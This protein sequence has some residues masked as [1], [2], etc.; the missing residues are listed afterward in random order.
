VPPQFAPSGTPAGKILQARLDA[1]VAQHPDLRIQVRIKPVDG[2]GGLLDSLTTSSAAAPLALPDLVALP[3]PL[4]ETAALKG[5]L[6]PF[7]GLI[8]DPEDSDWFDYALRL[9]HL[10]DSLF[11]LPFSG[12]ALVLVYRSEIISQP[13]ATMAQVLQ[14]S[15]ALAFPAADPQALFTLALYQAEGGEVL[16]G[17]GRPILQEQ[18]LTRVLTALLEGAQ[19]ERLPFWLTQFQSDDQAWEAFQRGQADMVITW[20]SRFLHT[21]PEGASMALLPTLDGAAF[22]LATGWMWALAGPSPESQEA[23]AQL[24]EFLSESD[25]LGEWTETTGYL[26]PHPRALSDWQDSQLR[27]F[28]RQVS[29]SAHLVPSADVLPGLAAPLV[30]ATAEML[31]LENDPATAAR[32]AVESLQ[33]P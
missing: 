31:K 33:A 30:E 23:A 25:F 17:E 28:I 8:A 21:R 27:T 9:A 11:G 10:Q 20:S 3:R 18:P 15:G 19:S 7:G 29:L 6:H 5:L 2:P 22:T 1:F 4:M 14:S 12:D 24:A 26:P 13:P 16:D 32:E